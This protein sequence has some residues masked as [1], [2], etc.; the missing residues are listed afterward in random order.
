[1]AELLPWARYGSVVV[2]VVMLIVVAQGAVD[3]PRH[4]RELWWPVFLSVA[5]IGVPLVLAREKR[6]LVLLGA[7]A[8]VVVRLAAAGFVWVLSWMAR[9]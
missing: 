3:S 2:V 9:R 8:Y 6:R 1:M 4:I 7:A 5:L